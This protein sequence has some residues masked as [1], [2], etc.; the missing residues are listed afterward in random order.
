[1]SVVPFLGVVVIGHVNH[2]KTALVRA[3]TGVETDRLPEEKAR[4][5]SIALGFAWRAYPEGGVDF[6]DAPGHEDFIRAM[7]MG[8]AGARTALLVVSAPEGIGRQTREHLQIA[9]LLGLEACLVA[10]TKADLVPASQ[11]PA[12]ES[13]L[14][15]ELAGS[16]ADAAPF[17]FCSAQTGEGL[18]ALHAALRSRVARSPPPPSLPGALLPLDRVFTLPGAGT[19]VT[20]SLQ[21][22]TLS[23]GGEAV[24]QPSGRRVYLRQIQVHG[25]SV[26]AAHPGDRAAAALRGVSAGEVEVGEVL[27]APGALEPSSRVDIRLRVAPGA[28][29]S[30]RSGDEVRVLWG[31]RQDMARVRLLDPS[32][33]EPGREGL[34]Q[35]RF[36]APVPVHSGQRLILRRPS[37]AE[38]LAGGEVLDP[39]APV[40]R[41]KTLDARRVLLAAAAAGDLEGIAEAL[42]GRD[43]G[44]VSLPEARRLSRRP[45]GEVEAWLER[46]RRRLDAGLFASEAALDSAS[47]AY[48]DALAQAHQDQPARA[49]VSLGAL[50]ARLA[51]RLPADLVAHVEARLLAEGAIRIAR[52]QVALADHDPFAALSPEETARLAS[53]E[54]AFRSGGVTPPDP[55]GFEAG[56]VDLLVG[57]GRMTALRNHALRQTLVFH[58][59]ALDAALETLEATFPPPSEFTTGQAR[60]ALST[61][62]KFIVPILECLDARGDTVRRGDVRQVLRSRNRFGPPPV[63]L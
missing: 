16:A 30:L 29:R 54:A 26:P 49:H 59:D 8:A 10:V 22:G 15:G 4:G 48:L 33:L 38:T 61:S 23:T 28:A 3:L 25:Q 60:A 35:L 2:G 14:R 1:M 44:A 11:R 46:T 24:L 17:V 21:G 12:L 41:A 62:R 37:P 50:R 47:R 18:E 52:G 6:L 19:V 55:S 27:C 34:A 58:L 31:A 51:R 42:A 53:I 56:L 40:L 43:G 20:G 7:V 13:R 36:S 5:M 45:A 39:L 57:S 9:G 63:P 32:S